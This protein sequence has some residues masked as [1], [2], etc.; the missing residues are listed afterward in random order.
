M[1]ILV[2]ILFPLAPAVNEAITF[3]FMY[4]L[5]TQCFQSIQML[6]RGVPVVTLSQ[7][8]VHL[9]IDV[10][11]DQSPPNCAKPGQALLAVAIESLM[12][13]DHS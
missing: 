2:M 10:A 3:H 6:L 11:W 1:M 9:N 5:H 4:R 8:A 13:C 12:I 7:V